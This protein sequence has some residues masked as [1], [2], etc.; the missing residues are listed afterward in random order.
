MGFKKVM[1]INFGEPESPD[2]KH[3]AN[4]RA[5]MYGKTKDWLL[6]GSIPEKDERIDGLSRRE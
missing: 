4:M 5:Y 6:L 1:E 2:V 3:L